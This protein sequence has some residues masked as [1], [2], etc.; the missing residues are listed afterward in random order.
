[1][2]RQSSKPCPSRSGRRAW[3]LRPPARAR[4]APIAEGVLMSRRQLMRH[5]EGGTFDAK[6]L[7][8]AINVLKWFVA[9]ASIDK[10]IADIK[11]LQ[12][13]RARHDATRPDTT[14]RSVSD[15]AE[16]TPPR[17][18]PLVQQTKNQ[19]ANRIYTLGRLTKF[20]HMFS[21]SPSSPS[22]RCASACRSATS[23]P[24]RAWTRPR[25]GRSPTWRATARRRRIGSHRHCSHR[26]R[27]RRRPR[28][29]MP[30]RIARRRPDQ[31]RQEL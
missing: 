6:K 27:R 17:P 26:H 13:M 23:I 24:C 20:E 14:K 3:S 7:P 9:P 22:W 16:P 30:R 4:G 11:T 12:E 2:A 1:M 10:S 28:L 29:R 5:C 15:A 19:I 8:A 18:D 21:A 31:A 25:T